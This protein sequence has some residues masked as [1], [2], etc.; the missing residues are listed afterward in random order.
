MNWKL[1][2]AIFGFGLLFVVTPAYASSVKANQNITISI[3]PDRSASFNTELSLQNT[4]G[5]V[6]TE[7]SAAMLASGVTNVELRQNGANI[8][9]YDLSLDLVRFRLPQPLL[10]GNSANISIN[11]AA[12]N[13]LAN[14]GGAWSL[15]IPKLG[16]VADSTGATKWKVVSAVGV[17]PLIYSSKPAVN[18]LGNRIEWQGNEQMFFVFNKAQSQLRLEFEIEADEQQSL[19][20]LVYNLPYQDQT[21]EVQHVNLPDTQAFYSI[22]SGNYF[23]KLPAQRS[24]ASFKWRYLS[25]SANLEKFKFLP[26]RKIFWDLPQTVEDQTIEARNSQLVDAA[27]KLV[28]DQLR[29]AKANEQRAPSSI[30]NVNQSFADQERTFNSLE[31][32]QL[33]V[34]Y[35]NYAGIPARVSYGYVR[36]FDGLPSNQLNVPTAWVELWRA[37]RVFYYHPHIEDLSGITGKELP[38]A[39]LLKM[40]I[41]NLDSKYDTALGLIGDVALAKRPTIRLIEDEDSIDVI[42][43]QINVSVSVVPPAQSTLGW[44][45]Y[46]PQMLINNRS[47]VAVAITSLKVDQVE[48]IA[49]LVVNNDLYPAVLAGKQATVNPLVWAPNVFGGESKHD[50]QLSLTAAGVI[51]VKTFTYQLPILSNIGVLVLLALIALILILGWF[52]LLRRLSVWRQ[53]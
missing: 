9:V 45:A 11:Y 27:Y 10:P 38:G 31:Y 41:Y 6:L 26:A 48:D 49:S 51:T 12:K 8:S 43:P 14:S 28:L 16:Q 20:S 44:T 22:S 2:F 18:N 34:D 5:S 50:A 52:V 46:R 33:F 4:S 13:V 24:Q 53:R 40:G 7:L 19:S 37:E 30:A 25:A 29:P 35:L 3:F 39:L 15:Y 47:N 1:T 42:A 36:G 21:T 23:Q 32:A 17:P